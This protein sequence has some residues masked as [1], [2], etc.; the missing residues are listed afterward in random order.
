MIGA[1][2]RLR[3]YMTAYDDEG[4]A[5]GPDLYPAAVGGSAPEGGLIVVDVGV[6]RTAAYALVD[7]GTQDGQ[8]LPVAEAGFGSGTAFAG[9]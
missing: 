2:L 5:R 9:G 8:V 3:D 1:V 7:A 4:A 6:G